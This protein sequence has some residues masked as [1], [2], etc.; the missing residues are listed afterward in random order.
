MKVRILIASALCC[1]LMCVFVLTGSAANTVLGD[2]DG[3]SHVTFDDAQMIFDYVSGNGSLTREQLA[4]ADIDGDGRVTVADAAQAFHYVTGVL[5]D[6]PYVQRSGGALTLLS[7]PDK[8][9]YTVGEPLDLSGMEVGITYFDGT[10]KKVSG[11]SVT[12][13]EPTVGTKII[14]V[15][16][17]GMR[18]AFTVTVYPKPIKRLA[19]TSLPNKRT[20]RK[21][22]AL[23]LTGLKVTAYYEDGTSEVIDSYAVSG[24]TGDTGVNTIKIQYGSYTVS[25]DVTVGG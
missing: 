2:L 22:E 21:G 23:N 11:Y 4:Y 10:S 14:T 3:D 8:V 13:Y 9:T 12:G 6:L 19:I 25:F 18:T 1:S 15:S 7:L 20:Y 24:F 16:Y 5:R 17:E